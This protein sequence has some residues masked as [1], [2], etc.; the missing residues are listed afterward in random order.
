MAFFVIFM[1]F[2]GPI[3]IYVRLSELARVRPCFPEPSDEMPRFGELAEEATIRKIRIV[4][5]LGRD[6]EFIYLAN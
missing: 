3:L 5:G 1:V 6:R 4:H 2:T